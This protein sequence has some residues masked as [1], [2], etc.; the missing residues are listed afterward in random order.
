MTNIHYVNY[1]KMNI[2]D[3]HN[4]Q[5]PYKLQTQLNSMY[6]LPQHEHHNTNTVFHLRQLFYIK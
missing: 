3:V 1:V 2:H 5:F 6:K 4:T